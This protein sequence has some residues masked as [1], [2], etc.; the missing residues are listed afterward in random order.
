M[1]TQSTKLH[2]LSSPSVVKSPLHLTLERVYFGGIGSVISGSCFQSKRIVDLGATN[3]IR[4]YM[5]LLQTLG[6]SQ[7]GHTPFYGIID[8]VQYGP[9]NGLVTGGT[10]PIHHI[11]LTIQ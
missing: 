10:K 11:L 9:H 2:L 6:W 3:N 4:A 7:W 8:L 5:D 1:G